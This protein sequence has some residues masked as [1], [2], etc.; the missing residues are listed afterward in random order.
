MSTSLLVA[1]QVLAANAIKTTIPSHILQNNLQYNA[2]IDDVDNGILIGRMSRALSRQA[3]AANL[4][5]DV[6]VNGVSDHPGKI[7]KVLISSALPAAATETMTF[8]VLKNAVSIFAATIVF[9]GSS[10]AGGASPAGVYDVTDLVT[11][12]VLAAGVAA[13]DVWTVTRVLANQSTLT[14]TQVSIDWG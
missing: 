3:A 12:A 5:A 8:D 13:G 11:A 4:A 1:R 14:T 6:C 7:R 10:G 9:Q 2:P